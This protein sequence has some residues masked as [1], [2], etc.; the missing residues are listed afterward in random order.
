MS[1]Q[2]LNAAQQAAVERHMVETTQQL[3]T[4]IKLRQWAVEQALT[5][6]ARHNEF[7]D[8]KQIFE[9]IYEFV[10]NAAVNASVPPV[11]DSANS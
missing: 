1:D 5:H 8:L 4:N 11:Q 7:K 2:H 9:G 10:S 6:C 3:L